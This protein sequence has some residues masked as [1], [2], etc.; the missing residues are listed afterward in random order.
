LEIVDH[1]RE[2][3]RL[4]YLSGLLKMEQDHP[5]VHDVLYQL[6]VINK[7]GE[8]CIFT[9]LDRALEAMEREVLAAYEHECADDH[10]TGTVDQ[11]VVVESNEARALSD[12]A[13]RFEGMLEQRELAAGEW[14]FHAGD[15]AEKLAIVRTGRLALIKQTP[16]GEMRVASI[17]PGATVNIRTLFNDTLV[18]NSVFAEE[19][20]TV[21][22]MSREAL[23]RSFEHNPVAVA[24]L[25]RDML[26]GTLRRL[27]VLTGE[28]SLAEAH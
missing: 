1:L 10:E 16:K 22:L 2:N 4:V 9:T 21:Y 28:L 18:N 13:E 6:D 11:N 5:G 19:P 14:L 12:L 27:D 3:N 24:A 25:F 23:T 7:V 15:P 8:D 17:G 20:T 26:Q